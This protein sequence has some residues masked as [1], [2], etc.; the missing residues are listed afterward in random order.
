MVLIG[1]KGLNMIKTH[2]MNF[3]KV[4]LRKI[5]HTFCYMK[6][7]IPQTFHSKDP[8]LSVAVTKATLWLGLSPLI[9]F[10][11]AGPRKVS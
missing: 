4:Q 11:L 3:S 6:S 2:C 8:M 7:C 10:S 9:H 5:K 1:E